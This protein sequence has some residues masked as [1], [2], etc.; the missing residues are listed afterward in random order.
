MVGRFNSISKFL[1]EMTDLKLIILVTEDM[2]VR[3]HPSP[4]M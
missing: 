1:S 3:L 2:V 4:P